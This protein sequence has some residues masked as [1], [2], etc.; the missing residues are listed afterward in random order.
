MLFSDF[1]VL[2][3]NPTNSASNTRPVVI[4]VDKCDNNLQASSET[5]FMKGSALTAEP[6]SLNNKEDIVQVMAMNKT[7][8][9]IDLGKLV[10]EK[11]NPE[12]YDTALKFTQKQEIETPESIILK[13]VDVDFGE[14]LA[15][16]DRF[17]ITGQVLEENNND[18][19]NN[20]EL[21][22]AIADEEKQKC[23]TMK[24]TKSYNKILKNIKGTENSN[25]EAKLDSIDNPQLITNLVLVDTSD[26]KS[27]ISQEIE[28]LKSDMS[29]K[30]ALLG[31]KLLAGGPIHPQYFDSLDSSVNNR[32]SKR[33]E[34]LTRLPV[35]TFDELRLLDYDLSTDKEISIV[36]VSIY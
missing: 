17:Q 36:I 14:E 18:D 7:L 32:N 19:D 3:K 4:G 9:A 21:S 27:F 6:S 33:A 11:D 10:N 22:S 15:I 30:I 26:L 8:E 20:Y 13:T 28:K 23:E 29:N 24:K 2:G 31:S 25:A 12:R 5:T 34:V 35:N 16:T 1:I